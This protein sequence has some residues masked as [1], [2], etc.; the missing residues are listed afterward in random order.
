MFQ[1]FSKTFVCQEAF[2]LH[3]VERCWRQNTTQEKCSSLRSH[4]AAEVC[5][6]S[7]DHKR[8]RVEVRRLPPMVWVSHNRSKYLCCKTFASKFSV[9]TSAP[10]FLVGCLAGSETRLKRIGVESL[11]KTPLNALFVNGRHHEEAKRRGTFEVNEQIGKDNADKRW[12]FRLGAY[13]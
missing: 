5:L 2:P 6:S 1:T 13:H 3:A 10:I 8:F 9:N 11:T 7:Y 12:V 4:T